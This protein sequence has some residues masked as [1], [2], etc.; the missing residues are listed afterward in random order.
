MAQCQAYKF[1]TLFELVE[2]KR[3]KLIKKQSVKTKE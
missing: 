2:E 1:N 3:E